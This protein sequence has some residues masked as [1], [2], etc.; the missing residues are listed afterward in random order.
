MGG[1][2]H[3]ECNN[4]TRVGF[5]LAIVEEVMPDSEGVVHDVKL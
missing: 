3:V 1:I 4:L 5:T 2:M